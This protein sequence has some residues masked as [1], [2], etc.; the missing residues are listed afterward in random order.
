MVITGGEPT[1]TPTGGQA[2]SAGADS[3]YIDRYSPEVT[4]EVI[5]DKGLE[6][7]KIIVCYFDRETQTNVYQEFKNETEKMKLRQMLLRLLMQEKEAQ[8]RSE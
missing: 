2:T 5:P 3:T 4:M 7:Y 6:L 1:V 8:I